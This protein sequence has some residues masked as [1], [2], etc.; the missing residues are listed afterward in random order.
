MDLDGL[1][2]VH[3]VFIFVNSVPVYMLSNTTLAQIFSVE[4]AAGACAK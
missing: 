4:S 3:V 2:G 1:D